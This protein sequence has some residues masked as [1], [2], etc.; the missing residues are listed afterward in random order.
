MFLINGARAP[1]CLR[2]FFL[3]FFRF[4]LGFGFLSFDGFILFILSLLFNMFLKESTSSS[5][6]SLI[7]PGISGSVVVDVVGD[8][9]RTELCGSKML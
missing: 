2:R 3:I 8:F 9:I 7:W 6:M 5:R 4:F 1:P